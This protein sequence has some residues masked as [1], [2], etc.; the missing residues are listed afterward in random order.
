M[1]DTSNNSSFSKSIP[2]LQIAWDSTSLG[3]LKTCPRLYYYSVVLG[4]QPKV[5]SHHLIFGLHYHAALERYDHAK[6]QGKDHDTAAHEAVRY[7]LEATW[8]DGRPWISYDPNKSRVTLVRTVAWYLEQFREDPIETITLSNG[9]PAVE[10]SFRFETTYDRPDAQGKFYLCGHIDRLGKLNSQI[11]VCDRKT[12]KY[13]LGPDFFDKFNPDNQ[14]TLYTLAANVVWSLPVQGVIIDGA[15]VAVT[16]SRFER[17]YSPR[18]K[19]QL[20]EWYADLAYWFSAA[21]HFAEASHWPQND[22]ACGNYGGCPFRSICAKSPSTRDQ[23]LASGFA[24]RVWDPLQ[25]RGDV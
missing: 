21:T 15:Q 11:Y 10:L 13:T 4:Y 5:L 1:L 24:R 16:F 8:E 3:Q 9:K 6:C 7:A 25:V 23:W 22:K 17:G 19:D 18:T 20:D 2:G 14:M 12:S